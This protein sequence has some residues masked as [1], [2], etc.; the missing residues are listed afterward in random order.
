M[1][2]AGHNGWV[3][4]SQAH[5]WVLAANTKDG[6]DA[7]MDDT[8]TALPPPSGQSCPLPDLSSVDQGQLVLVSG[9]RSWAW[10]SHHLAGEEGVLKVS[11]GA[12]RTVADATFVLGYAL[13]CE[14]PGRPSGVGTA[15]A[16]LRHVVIDARY[17]S[18]PLVVALQGNVSLLA[19]HVIWWA[20]IPEPVSLPIHVACSEAT[21]ALKAEV[22]AEIEL[23]AWLPGSPRAVV[24]IPGELEQPDVPG[25]WLRADAVARVKAHPKRSIGAAADMAISGHQDLFGLAT[26]G[27][28]EPIDPHS[29]YGLRLIAESATDPNV[30]C[31]AG[32]AAA[33]V[34]LH[35]G[36]GPEAMERLD[37]TLSRTRLADPVHRAT[38]LWAEALVY[39]DMGEFS[40]AA[41]RFE[42]ATEAVHTGRDLA[43]LATM[44]RQWAERLITRGLLED[45]SVHLRTARGLYRRLGDEEG[46]SAT[47]R[48]AADLAVLLSEHV[49]AEAL[50]EQAEMTTTTDVEQANRIVGQLGLAIAQGEWAHARSLLGR[51][52]RMGVSN[53]VVE[54]NIQR[55]EA[56]LA[57]R[58]GD[59]VTALEAAKQASVQYA[60]SG[61]ES[62]AARCWRL[63]G[64]AEA[65]QGRTA[66]ALALYRRA[67]HAQI[68][69]GDWVGMQTTMSHASALSTE[70]VGGQL[71][72]LSIE[73]RM[74]G[75]A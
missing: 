56:D 71:D 14:S 57:L 48:G 59:W 6:D 73:L 11:L 70:D 64:D 19:S 47:L 40:V 35:I 17:A 36:Q 1:L 2:G 63:A 62:A 39:L 29:L 68:R 58:S 43:L 74:L 13:A 7:V 45:A 46:M 51:L 20:A 32:A 23:A 37:Q 53:R 44:H 28:V 24:A 21:P 31:L 34:R 33:R 38:L 8:L 12:A 54:A 67:A 10:L 22:P 27:V 5:R 9:W 52:K 75:S 15:A 4:P 61:E 72:R 66:E 60:S 41:A 65:L 42:E 3:S 69:L 25:R 30:A 18:A 50:Y 49:S 55:R 26:G 16:T